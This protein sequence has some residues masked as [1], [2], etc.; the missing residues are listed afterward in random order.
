LLYNGILGDRKP[1]GGNVLTSS[2]L[3]HLD[4]LLA[5][6][7]PAGA[8]LPQRKVVYGETSRLGEQRLAEAGVTFRQIPYDIKAR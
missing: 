1:A 3:T 2:V 4:E 6:A 5:A 7:T 8:S